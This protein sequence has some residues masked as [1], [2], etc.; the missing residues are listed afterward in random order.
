MSDWPKLCVPSHR[1]RQE[2]RRPG[3]HR[4]HRRRPG[5]PAGFR[6]FQEDFMLGISLVGCCLTGDCG[7]QTVWPLSDRFRIWDSRNIGVCPLLLLQLLCGHDPIF[8]DQPLRLSSRSGCDPLVKDCRNRKRICT[9]HGA[10]LK[11][12]TLSNFWGKNR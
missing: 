2:S 1:N 10:T 3:N 5:S 11:N 6:W 4:N 8:L 7:F 9:C 12:H